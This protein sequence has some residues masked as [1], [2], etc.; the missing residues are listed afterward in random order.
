MA[1]DKFIKTASNTIIDYIIVID[2]SNCSTQFKAAWNTNSNGYGRAYKNDGT[3]LACDWIN[4][5]YAAG[6]G[7]VKIR[8]SGIFSAVL[9]N[10]LKLY[11]PI[12]S[13]TQYSESSTYGKNNVYTDYIASYPLITG[14]EERTGKGYDLVVSGAVLQS[15]GGYFFDG[16]NDRLREGDNKISVENFQNDFTVLSKFN[17]LSLGGESDDGRLYEKAEGTNVINGFGSF[18]INLGVNSIGF[19]VNAG[20][21]VI[22]NE[23]SFSTIYNSAITYDVSSGDV[24]HY[25]NGSLNGTPASTNV[26]GIT[27]TNPLTIGNRSSGI[28][29]GFHG[30]IYGV[31]FISGILSANW[32]NEYY[33]QDIDNTTYWGSST[34]E[35]DV[36]CKPSLSIGIRSAIC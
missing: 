2:L 18:C 25:I 34:W 20:T 9:P 8:W 23:L 16:D 21:P 4:L 1:Y 19:K 6:T 26:A 27:T 7:I 5:N 12:S 24:T 17:M 32:I 31:D 35:P 36:I 30:Y 14:P 33:L 13:R 11:P 3:E 15:G 28:D 22:T 10:I 29:K